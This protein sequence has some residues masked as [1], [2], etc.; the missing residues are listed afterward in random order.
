[1]YPADNEQKWEYNGIVHQ[2]FIDLK[3][4]YDSDRREVLYS[5]L[6]EFGIPGKLVRLSKM[7]L[8]ETYSTVCIGKLQSDKFPIHN[9][10]KQ[11]DTS[12][13]LFFNF[14]FRIRQ[15]EDPREPGRAEI[16]RDTPAFG[17]I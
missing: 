13:P 11:G 3:K 10:L 4:A 8:N 17:L 15:S 12:S 1:L 9:V 14:A 6:S 16:E 2:L 7:C 5:I